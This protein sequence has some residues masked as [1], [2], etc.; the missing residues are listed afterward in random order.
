[1]PRVVDGSKFTTL[2]VTVGTGATA[3]YT[4]PAN[5]AAV[6]RLLSLNNNNAAAK[7]ITSQYYDS[8]SYVLFFN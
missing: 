8:K 2:G 6:V 5:H 7:K 4:V 1:M 3:L